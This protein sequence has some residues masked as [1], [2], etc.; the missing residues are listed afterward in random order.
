MRWRG[1][2]VGHFRADLVVAQTG[3]GRASRQ[4]ERRGGLV[5]D[6]L[7]PLPRYE[8]ALRPVDANHPNGRAPSKRDLA[9]IR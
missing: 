1:C 2:P 5:S 8:F 9:S 6:L 3:S 7:S 4:V